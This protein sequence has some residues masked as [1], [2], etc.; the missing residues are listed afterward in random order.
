MRIGNEPVVNGRAPP[1]ASCFHR[2]VS[3]ELAITPRVSVVIPVLNEAANLPHVFRSLPAWVDEVILVD[4]GST[5]GTI[6]VARRLLPDAK[7]ITQPGIGKGDALLA[8]FA[9]CAGDIIVTMDGDGSTDGR[10]IIRFVSALA[11]GADFVKGSRYGS[12]GGSDDLTFSR[13][14]G[15]RL[16]GILVNWM[17]G[18]HFSDLCYGYN[19]FWSRYL[20]ALAIDCT[21]FEVE[22]LMHIRAAV[23]DLKIQEVPSFEHA[24]IHGSSN[25]RVVRDG[26][27]ILA[28]IF[29]ERL[30]SRSRRAVCGHKPVTSGCAAGN[31]PEDAAHAPLARPSPD[32]EA[33]ESLVSRQRIP[34]PAADPG[35]A[36][37]DA[38]ASPA[39]RPVSDAGKR[40]AA[41]HEVFRE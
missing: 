2:H 31:T 17:F 3:A 15:N 19:G 5:D 11:A 35:K 25:L 4:G 1:G 6:A 16:L 32:D 34:Q 36:G 37:N 7:V 39:N 20:P 41:R 13:R 23:A 33:D 40:S 18:T 26:C 10:E 9:A 21:G 27:R 28:L 8:G 12:G 22:T 14:L 30:A 29:R 24:R 38:A